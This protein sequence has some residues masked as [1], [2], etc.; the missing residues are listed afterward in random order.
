MT[1]TTSEGFEIDDVFLSYREANLGSGE[2]KRDEFMV[3]QALAKSRMQYGEIV[4]WK[5]ESDESSADRD[6][7]EM[8]S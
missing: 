2:W 4:S 1:Y 6:D 7:F 8:V 3:E 5:S